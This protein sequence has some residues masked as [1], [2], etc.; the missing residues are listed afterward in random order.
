MPAAAPNSV[1]WALN[2]VL[3]RS[4]RADV[5][6][7]HSWGA[8]DDLTAVRDGDLD[9]AILVGP[10][11]FPGLQT[12]PLL[13]RERYAVVA[14]DHPLAAKPI[15][16]FDDI[17]D[18]PTF[19]RPER[20]LPAW[21]AYWLN[22]EERGTEPAYLGSSRCE[23]DAFVAIANGRVVGVAP[24]GW[25]RRP[26][27]ATR[28]VAD[29]P[30][31]EIVLITRRERPKPLLNA[32]SRALRDHADQELTLAERRIAAFVARGYTDHQIAN[33]LHLSARTVESHVANA[34]RRLNLRSRAH[35]AVQV[36]EQAVLHP[37]GDG[38]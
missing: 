10:V 30:A 26:G 14:E 20:V 38:P 9:A 27:L 28:L 2:R 12:S 3:R 1:A 15:L 33:F 21:R 36:T 32:F 37:T 34:R 5:T 11:D 23:F 29:L 8:A 18:L 6:V 22:V 35:L 13:M 7:V 17:I 19:R 24:D 4:P 16:R 25:G 31:V